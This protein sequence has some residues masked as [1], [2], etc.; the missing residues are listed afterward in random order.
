MS[1]FNPDLMTGNIV[2]SRVRLARNLVGYPFR[3]QSEKSA[4]EIVKKVNRALV[5]CDSFNLYCV[6]NLDKMTLEAMK[7]RHLISPNLINNKT[8]GAVLV[9]GDESLAIMINEED[10]IREQCF[11]KGLRLFEAYKRLD[12][13]DDELSKNLDVA[14]NSKFGYLTACPTNVG[15]G[16]RASVMLFLPALT[17][18]GK[19]I[20]VIRE[21]EKIG[22]TVRG[23]Y[24][25][26]SEAEGYMYQVSNEITIGISEYD[27]LSRVENAVQ[28]ICEKER[29]LMELLYVKNELKT[30]D[31]ARKSYGVLT[32]AVLL[33]YSEF[34]Q[35][36]AEVKLGAMLG[37]IGINDVEQIDNLIVASRPSMLCYNYGKK[38]NQTERDILRAEIVAQKLQKLRE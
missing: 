31:R 16:L 36:I 29:E 23:L 14:Y 13:I 8:C 35:R 25:E 26:G 37:M 5:K 4:R 27:I 20:S 24:G 12:K 2:K 38:L 28:K 11:M 22:L 17:E 21:V 18:S 1:V 10:V 30:M 9:N 19:I 6:S 33:P 34:L 7:E 32:N 15:T 3:V